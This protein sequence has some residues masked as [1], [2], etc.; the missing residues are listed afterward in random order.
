MEEEKSFDKLRM[1]SKV[2][3]HTQIPTI[4]KTVTYIIDENG[5]E[6]EQIESPE[7]KED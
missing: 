4:K 5:N 1:V 2:E 6:V 7:K 3:P